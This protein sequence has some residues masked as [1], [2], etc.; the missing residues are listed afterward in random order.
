MIT[1]ALS[2]VASDASV[3][4]HLYE[5]TGGANW[6][7]KD[8]WLTGEP[9]QG[10]GWASSSEYDCFSGELASSEQP[11]CCE[12]TEM[13]D[14]TPHVVRL[15]L[16]RNN[17]VGTVPSQ[18]ARISTLRLLV[19]DENSLSGSL[20]T[21]LTEL[22]HLNVLWLQYNQMS[23]SLPTELAK[24]PLSERGCML[25]RNNFSFCPPPP[26]SPPGD[27]TGAEVATYP[28]ACL[29]AYP[30]SPTGYLAEPAGVCVNATEPDEGGGGGGGGT[31]AWV[32]A[33]AVLG[34]L[35]GAAV[36]YDAYQRIQRRRRRKDG[37][38]ALPTD[39]DSEVEARR[40]QDELLQRRQH[41]D[42]NTALGAVT[43]LPS[44]RSCEES[45]ASRTTSARSSACS[46]PSR[47]S[48]RWSLMRVIRSTPRPGSTLTPSTTDDPEFL[49]SAKST[50]DATDS[51]A[52]TRRG[53][54]A[55]D[56]I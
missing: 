33:I 49:S 35:V 15:D 26:P 38:A 46:Q 10:A 40:E 39:R 3:L 32:I 56:R 53:P 45:G 50:T 12:I 17:L 34:G 36:A 37:K 55:T 7:R 51:D 22:E 13:D 44:S 8:G 28:Q 43:T 24:L 19:L 42:L 27:D 4:R 29:D 2:V 21:Q 9:C 23:G 5:V 30:G 31:P 11:V 20:P 6:I 52:G 47:A 48:H 1:L 16:W 41:L 25:Q 54:L 18:L 14:T